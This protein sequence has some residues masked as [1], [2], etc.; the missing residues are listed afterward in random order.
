MNFLNISFFLRNKEEPKIIQPVEIK[1][2]RPAPINLY[3]R[4][5]KPLI[6]KK[7]MGTTPPPPP[8]KLTSPPPPPPASTMNK[9][10]ADNFFAVLNRS[11]Q[12]VNSPSK[13]SYL[14]NLSKLQS[15][16]PSNKSNL[17]SSHLQNASKIKSSPPRPHSINQQTSANFQTFE[18]KAH[19]KP[20]E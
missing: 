9:K 20:K 3:N 5:E 2:N 1:K 19:L 14:N 11:K 17:K 10:K 18:K 6:D 4:L 15:S 7:P 16:E 13:T 12:K 8:P